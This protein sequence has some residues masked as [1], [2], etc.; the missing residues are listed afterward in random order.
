MV[1]IINYNDFKLDRYE[2]FRNNFI[3]KS[4]NYLEIY[5]DLYELEVI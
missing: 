5:K 2:N 3:L 4:L 1:G